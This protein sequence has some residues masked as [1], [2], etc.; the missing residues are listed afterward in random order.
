VPVEEETPQKAG[1]ESVRRAFSI[2]RCFSLDRSELG[3]TE[4][5]RELGVHKSTVSRLLSTLESE[6]I[7]IQ[8]PESGRYRLGVGLLEMAGWV[9]LHA[10]LRRVAHPL[11]NQLAQLTQESVNLAVLDGDEVVNIEYISPFGRHVMNIGWVGRR[12]PLHASSTGKVLM[13]YLPRSEF[14]AILQKPLPKFTENTLLESSELQSE[15]TLIREQGYATGLEELEIG[16]NAV[17]A[18]IRD[19]TGRVIAAISISGPAN[20]LSKERIQDVLVQLVLNFV[21]RISYELGY[22]EEG[23]TV[24]ESN[25]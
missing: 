15:R 1:V 17:A 19:H 23:E 10:D 12:T 20:R 7:V 6:R 22:V 14:E 8:N 5:G 16:L 11:L 24:S 25:P 3:V 13:A 18:P 21:Q 2:L 9:T 4:I